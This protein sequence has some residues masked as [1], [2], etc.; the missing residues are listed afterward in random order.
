MDGDPRHAMTTVTR[1][2]WPFA[3]SRLAVVRL[4]VHAADATDEKGMRAALDDAFA[5]WGAFDGVVHCGRRA[6]NGEA[7]STLWRWGI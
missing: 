3:R 5:C 4:T 1:I 2:I 6:G 7:C